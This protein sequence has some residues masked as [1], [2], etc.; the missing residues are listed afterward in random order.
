L[1]DTETFRSDQV[2]IK[3][4]HTED[5]RLSALSAESGG[6]GFRVAMIPEPSTAL[7]FG[8]GLLA[9]ATRRR[10]STR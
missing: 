5:V 10:C 7:L 8:I 1:I 6:I 3:T 2:A 4:G 9:L